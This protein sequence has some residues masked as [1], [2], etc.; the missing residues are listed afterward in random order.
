MSRLQKT[1]TLGVAASALALG[2]TR[3]ASADTALPPLPVLK[4]VWVLQLENKS[5]DEAFTNNSNSYLWTQLPP[6]GVLLREEYGTGHFS[7][8][9]YISQLSGQAA[10]AE[11]RADCPKY[12]DVTPTTTVPDVGGGTAEGINAGQVEGAGCVYPATTKT[13]ADQL[14]AAGKTWHGWMGDMGNTPAREQTSCGM[15]ATNGTADDPTV[16]IASASSDDTQSATAA[17]QYAARHNPFVYFHSIID[18]QASCKANVRPLT[19]LAATLSTTD[20]TSTPN[21]NFITPN[22]CDDAHDATCAGSNLA[23]NT[24]GGLFSADLFLKKYV[25]LITGSAAFVDGG[26]LIVDF[27]EGDPSETGGAISCCGGAGAP[28]ITAPGTGG[29][30]TGAVIISPF[31]KP[32]SGA[33]MVAY[34]HYS[35]LRSLEDGFGITT[36]GDDGLGHL[37]Y[38]AAPTGARAATTDMT[39]TTAAFVPYGCD[40]YTAYQPCLAA[41]APLPELTFPVALPVLGLAVGGAVVARRR[42]TRRS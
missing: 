38:A 18:N 40:V 8:D 26:M 7:L 17:D 5:Y 33:D 11:T 1:I 22:L 34:N 35:L 27:D 28:N 20:D 37:G 16:P 19:E 23:G 29:G 9:N 30:L 24:Q 10:N 21:F 4:H 3:S 36:G 2:A 39:A 41:T 14:T 13:L 12:T 6:M 31:T 25:P 32:N 15:P 42:R